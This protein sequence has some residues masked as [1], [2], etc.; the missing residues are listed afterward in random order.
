[1]VNLKI[2]STP[3]QDN[4]LMDVAEVKGNTDSWRGCLGTC[5]LSKISK[6]QGRISC[7]FWNVVDWKKVAERYEVAMP[8]AKAS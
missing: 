3:N 4:P 1:M 8:K 2:T 5:L 6:S 7:A